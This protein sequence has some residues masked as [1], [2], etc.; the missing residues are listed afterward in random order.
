MSGSCMRHI[1]CRARA[2]HLSLR[3]GFLLY[4]IALEPEDYMYRNDPNFFGHVDLGKQCRP[5]SG[6]AV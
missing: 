3:I 2:Q 5:R 4:G 6:G 1:K